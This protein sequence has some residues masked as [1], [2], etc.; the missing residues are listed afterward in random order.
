MRKP[1]PKSVFLPERYK[2]VAVSFCIPGG[3]F[4]YVNSQC[5]ALEKLV[6]AERWERAFFCLYSLRSSSPAGQ[7]VAGSCRATQSSRASLL[8]APVDRKDAGKWF[9]GRAP[10]RSTPGL[11]YVPRPNLTNGAKE[12][13]APLAPPQ[14]VWNA[15]TGRAPSENSAVRSVRCALHRSERA[16]SEQERSQPSV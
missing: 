4:C 1:E 16:F 13:V 6:P 15:F 2:I 11:L 8:R 12:S 9:P 10:V 3:R 7:T 5:D 14:R